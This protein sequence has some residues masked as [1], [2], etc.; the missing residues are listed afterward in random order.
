MWKED[1]LPPSASYVA[2]G[3]TCFHVHP[4]HVAVI[5]FLKVNFTAV[6]GREASLQ[7]IKARTEPQMST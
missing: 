2:V 4:P 5:S 6:V 7:K 1:K 3:R